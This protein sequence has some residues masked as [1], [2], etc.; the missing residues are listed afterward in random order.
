MNKESY[1]ETSFEE[2]PEADSST[3]VREDTVTP[4]ETEASESSQTESEAT[5]EHKK[6]PLA[7]LHEERS[8]R[9]ALQKEK[10]YLDTRLELMENLLRSRLN[11]NLYPPEEGDKNSDSNGSDLNQTRAPSRNMYGMDFYPEFIAIREEI[12]RLKHPDY[13]DVI[14]GFAGRLGSD[15][16]LQ[17]AVLNADDPTEMAYKLAKQG[18]DIWRSGERESTR[19]KAEKIE[20]NLNAP[21]TPTA[22]GGEAF[23]EGVSIEK[24]LEMPHDEF[25]KIWDSLASA[26]RRRLCQG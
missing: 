3:D 2:R 1:E 4:S 8:R 10:E 23:P 12:A 7:A 17:Q 11:D 9:Q 19:K 6:V 14:K 22:R 25:S 20:K 21:K 24:L 15:I 18:S 13:D 16:A 26:Q 5:V